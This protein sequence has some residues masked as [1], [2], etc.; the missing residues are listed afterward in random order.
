MWSN[1]TIENIKLLNRSNNMNIDFIKKI[2]SI[3]KLINKTENCD[4]K[5]L[6]TKISNSKLNRLKETEWVDSNLDLNDNLYDINI[7]WKNKNINNNIFMRTTENKF[8]KIKNRLPMFIKIFNFI[9]DNSKI[10]IKMYLILSD[11]KK[12]LENN[13]II[14]PKHINSGYTNIQTNE[15][16]IWREEEFEKVS[17]HELIHLFDKDHRD[18]NINLN[19]N[20]NGPTSYFEAIT[21]FKA[22]IYNIIY[23][24]LLTFKKISSIIEF[25]YYFIYNQAKLISYNLSICKN[26]NIINQNSP[27]YSYYI[28]KYFIFEYFF[29]NLFDEK[30][31][32]NIFYKG[33]NY[34]ELIKLINIRDLNNIKHID[35]KSSRMTLFE[36]I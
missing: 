18:E 22:I 29:F 36:L 6:E 15:I 27:A 32:D 8:K 28:L 21:D 5:I 23:I 2:K 17:F 10:E 7:C 4:F 1:F 33:K 3:R 13:K 24:S 16:F 31:F 19:I 14:S 30:L 12:K 34:N 9:Q 11:L 35:F 20:I 26:E 25:E